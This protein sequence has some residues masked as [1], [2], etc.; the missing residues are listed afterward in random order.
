M[1]VG[2]DLA[3]SPW[4]LAS[5]ASKI[6]VLNMTF[7]GFILRIAEKSRKL[8]QLSKIFIFGPTEMCNASKRVKALLHKSV[9]LKLYRTQSETVIFMVE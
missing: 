6:L 5:E 9:Y 2:A 4:F 3:L 8:E 7:D 1:L